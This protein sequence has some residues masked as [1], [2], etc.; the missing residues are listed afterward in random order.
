MDRGA[1]RAIVHG[2]SK[3]L[4]MTRWLNNDS[5]VDFDSGGRGH[6][7]RTVGGLRE[8]AI[9]LHWSLRNLFFGTL[10]SYWCIFPFLLCLSLRFFSLFVRPPQTIILPFCITFLG[11]MVLITASCTM[12]QVFVHS[13][14]GTLSYLIHWIYLPIPLYNHKEFD[15]GHTWMV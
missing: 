10:H 3:E 7:V 11:G 6:V 5:I 15:L 9:S 4:H 8:L 12:L 1:W 2:V 13:S 14:S